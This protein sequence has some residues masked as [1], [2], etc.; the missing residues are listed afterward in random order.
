MCE[1]IMELEARRLEAGMSTEQVAAEM[2]V[3]R[4][5]VCEWES[6][7]YLPKTR[8]LPQLAEVLGCGIGSLFA[9]KM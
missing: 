7:L 1:K 8:Q 5:T 4:K 2:G 3:T 9:R 6:E